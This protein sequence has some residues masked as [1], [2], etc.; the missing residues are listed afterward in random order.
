MTDP[1]SARRHG[2]TGIREQLRRAPDRAAR[3]RRAIVFLTE[4]EGRRAGSRRWSSSAVPGR[5]RESL[6]RLREP[7]RA[8]SLLEESF[9][10][11]R[12]SGT[13]SSPG[14]AASAP[15]RPGRAVGTAPARPLL[16]P[17]RRSPGPQVPPPVQGLAPRCR[18][19]AQPM[20]TR[21]GLSRLPSQ[22]HSAPPVP[23]SEGAKEAEQC[24]DGLTRPPS[25]SLRG[26]RWRSPRS[27]AADSSR[28]IAA[29]RW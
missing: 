25:A 18:D 16:R 1:A 22:A 8:T 5:W 14:G 10:T 12:R 23:S 9:D 26:P 20:G 15:S 6:G 11:T 3:G 27:V 2:A 13:R 19:R 17:N 29:L 21:V 24:G 7:A 4:G 28:A